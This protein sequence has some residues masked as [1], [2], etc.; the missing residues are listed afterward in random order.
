MYNLDNTKADRTGKC[1]SQKDNPCC[2]TVWRYFRS[3]RELNFFPLWS[4]HNWQESSKVMSLGVLKTYQSDYDY[5]KLM[6]FCLFYSLCCQ[7]VYT[8]VRIWLVSTYVV[9]ERLSVMHEPAGVVEILVQILQNTPILKFRIPPQ[10]WNLTESPNSRV[11]EYPP[12]NEIWLRVQVQEF[13]N[14]PPPESP[15]PGVS[16]CPPQKKH[17]HTYTMPS[18]V[19]CGWNHIALWVISSLPILYT[20]A[21]EE[22]LISVAPGILLFTFFN[23]LFLFNEI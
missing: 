23:F 22:G 3:I 2:S 11:S 9:C 4:I 15:S 21:L 1:K 13:Q 10:K 16:E 20:A 19:H 5:G 17:T 12:K 8:A 6:I 18:S 7:P 14:T